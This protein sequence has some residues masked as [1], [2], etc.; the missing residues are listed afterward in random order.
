MSEIIKISEMD[1]LDVKEIYEGDQIELYLDANPSTGY[2][3]QITFIDKEILFQV[4]EEE[5]IA[6]SSKIG[7]KGNIIY[8]FNVLKSGFTKLE[9]EYCRPWQ[10]NEKDKKFAIQFK[11]QRKK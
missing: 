9:L 1:D 11:I 5:F 6:K 10:K 3:W 2:T 4:G 7:S 8:K